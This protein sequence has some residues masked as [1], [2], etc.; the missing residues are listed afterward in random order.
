MTLRSSESEA[1]YPS[2]APVITPIVTSIIPPC[3]TC[4]P[5]R[6]SG[7]KFAVLGSARFWEVLDAVGVWSLI[8]DSNGRESVGS[9]MGASACS[10]GVT[11][12]AVTNAF[13]VASAVSVMTV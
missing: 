4:R 9:L 11:Y 5:T 3:A 2:L 7:S 10:V 1:F 8:S 12:A 13:V 6:N